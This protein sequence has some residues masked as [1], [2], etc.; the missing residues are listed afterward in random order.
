MR[1]TNLLAIDTS[2]DYLSIA[3]MKDD[4]VVSLFHRKTPMSHSRLLV[5]TIDRMLRKS[6]IKLRQIDCFCISI[7]PGSFAGLRIGVTVVKGFSYILKKPIVAIPTLDVI[8]HNVKNYFGIICPVLDARK[9]KVYACLYRSDSK[10]MKK[11]SKYL[12]LP[13]REMIKKTEIYDKILFLG[14]AVEH[15]RDWHPRGDVLAR[16]GL[17]E[18]RKKRFVTAE[19]LEPLY[20]YSRECDIT[21]R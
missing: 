4:T 7:G 8:A 20:L 3:V 13:M 9:G 5:P 15:G 17:E 2:T 16:L 11:I 14:D 19:D 1:K 10:G 12:L 21:G 6:G 18:Y